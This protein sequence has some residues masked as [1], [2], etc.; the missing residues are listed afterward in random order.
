MIHAGLLPAIFD[1]L[2]S[3]AGSLYE[4]P[5]V[6]LRMPEAREGSTPPGMFHN[7]GRKGVVAARGRIGDHDPVGTGYIPAPSSVRPQASRV[8]DVVAVIVDGGFV[9]P[10]YLPAFQDLGPSCL[11]RYQK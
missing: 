4:E 7:A 1:D 9:G 6:R 2:K 3:M 5:A 8:R 10:S 11:D